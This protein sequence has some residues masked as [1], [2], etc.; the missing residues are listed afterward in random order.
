MKHLSFLRPLLPACLVTLALPIISLAAER[1][2]VFG[3]IR[4]FTVPSRG[5]IHALANDELRA[6][7]GELMAVNPAQGD[8]IRAFVK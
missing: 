7:I 4:A 3:N 1:R 2:E 8:A 6:L 5:T